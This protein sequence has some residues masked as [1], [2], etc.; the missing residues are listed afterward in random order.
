MMSSTFSCGP[1]LRRSL[2]R[3]RSPIPR[4]KQLFSSRNSLPSRP[5]SESL[6]YPIPTEIIMK[7]GHHTTDLRDILSMSLTCRSARVAL[8]PML[9]A[10]VELKTNRH[11]KAALEAFSRQPELTAQHIRSLIVRPNNVE[12]TAAGDHLNEALVAGL[13]IKIASRMRLLRSFCWD[14]QEMPDDRMW[15]ALRQFCPRLK[16]ISTS[17]GALP[18]GGSDYLFEFRDL[19]KF[20]LA[21]K[22]DSLRWL[23]DGRP[24]VEKLPR[25]FWQ[26]LIEHSPNLEELTIGGPAPSPRLLDARHVTAGRWPRLRKLT[27]GDVRLLQSSGED[28]KVPESQPLRN[29]LLAHPYLQEIAFLHPGVTGFPSDLPLPA[30]ALPR[31]DSFTSKHHDTPS[32]SVRFPTDLCDAEETSVP[33][34]L[35]LWIDLTF[36]SRNVVHDD[37]DTF[38]TLLECCPHLLHFEVFCFTRPAFHVKEFSV[39]L[40][41][42]APQLRSFS[43]T[44]IYKS[45]DEDMSHS[46]ARIAHD[47]RNIQNFTLRYAQESWLT[48]RSGRV[49][50]FGEYEVLPSVDGL[51]ASL[52]AYE[53]GLK[54]FGLTY[55]RN[56]CSGLYGRD[57]THHAPPS[58]S[59]ILAGVTHHAGV[60]P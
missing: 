10:T 7:V 38:R 3:S 49:H 13:V 29:F 1:D 12:R 11:C 19:R 39:A 27:L 37:G 25:R 31:M 35:T 36:A 30:F 16:S 41:R 52:L 32:L 28:E 42:A 15:L 9:Y 44:K 47:N 24:S 2:S 55:L 6:P 14:G 17:I 46:A 59:L 56:Y 22:S 40:R 4:I 5:P 34:V 57:V 18:L 23:T 54:P 51:P 48:H 53:W 26:M 21:V 45:S 33:K 60:V 50:Q 20:T 8:L 43:L 58:P